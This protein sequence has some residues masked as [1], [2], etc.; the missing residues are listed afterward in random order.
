MAQRGSGLMRQSGNPARLDPWS[1]L[2]EMRRTMD[3]VFNRFFG[4]TPMNRLFEGN[5]P[6]WGWEPNIELYETQD[7]LVFHADLPGYDREDVN[8]QVTA[9]T[10]QISA[11]HREETGTQ[12]PQNASAPAEDKATPSGT[13]TQ[14]ESG[15][16]SLDQTTGNSTAVQASQP[17]H[18][19][20]YHIQSR[21]R[22]SF[23]V[24]YSLPSEIDPNKVQAI[25]RNGVLEVHMPKAENAKPKQVTVDVQS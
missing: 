1:E 16:E 4:Y 2:H 5:A 18:P 14:G 19:R 24:S 22:Q 10:L 21:R 12:S 15:A 7:E 9:D 8:L 17:R 3:D 23:S 13:E 11:Q 25:F 6:A 20:T